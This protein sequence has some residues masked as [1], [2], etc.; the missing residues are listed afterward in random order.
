MRRV[1]LA[2]AALAGLAADPLPNVP[3]PKEPAQVSPGDLNSAMD[4]G[5]QFLVKNQNAD[6]SWGTPERT[7]ALN[8]MADP[9]GSHN[10]F[11]SGCT[12]LT[13]AALIETGGQSEEVIK[14]IERGEEW[15]LENLP[16]LKRGTQVELYNVWGHGYG[17][18]ALARMHGRKP[19]DAARKA[20]IEACLKEQYERLDRFASVDGGWGYYDFDI[21]AARP[22]AS[23]TSF[24]NAAVLCAL[25]EA[26]GIVAPPEKMVKKAFDATK[27]Q[28]KPDFTYL[29]GEYLKW[30]PHMDINLPAGSLGRSQA[31]NAAL[32]FWGDTKV[33]DQVMIDW[34]D[35]L[36]VRNGWLDMGRKRPVPHESHAKVAGYFYYF[37]HYYAGQC[38]RQIA[39]EKRAFYQ[40]HLAKIMLPHQETDGSW[41]DYPLYNYHQ[42]YGTAYALMTLNACRR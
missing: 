32:R 5:V 34:L 20:R 1:I 26:K 15:L 8:I 30:Q 41:W 4:R 17:V 2:T 12:A 28:Q 23:S 25:H 38:I 29:Y 24:V 7:K 42:S 33:T 18:L 14:A 21:G 22:A 11:R 16:K 6:G 31:C 36:V 3:R 13:V 9:P 40:D 37:G 35:R 10:A 39:P 27:R 19:D